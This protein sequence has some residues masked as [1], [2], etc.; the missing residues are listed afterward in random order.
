MT[1]YLM[2]LTWN[3]S[4]KL[5]RLHQSLMPALEGLDTVWL[6]KSNGCK[7]NTDQVALEWGDKVKVIVY[8]DINQN[9]SEGM[10]LLFSEASPTDNDLVLL[11][12]N[13]IIIKDPQSLKNMIELFQSD[14]KIGVVGARLLYTNTDL[15]QHA[16]VVFNNSHR[17]PIH[18]RSG[19]KTDMHAEKNRTFQALIGAALLT[20]AE[21]FR[22]VCTTNKN[23]A[24]GLDQEFRWAFDDVDLCLSIGYNMEKQ[25]VYCGNTDIF[26]DESITLKK[27]PV[28]KLFLTHNVARLV[29]K[30]GKR[31]ALDRNSYLS[32]PK[33]NL[34][35]P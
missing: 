13:D 23:G 15:L 21:Y 28:N 26:H 4:D 14:P 17:M 5:E 24:R 8:K 1:I 32:D 3:A 33:H 29:E 20:K 12:N 9:F 25:I 18:Y 31:Y 16:G 2:T 35:K 34:Y 10:N 11:L 22:H 19:E 6:I 7:D 30:W 27:N